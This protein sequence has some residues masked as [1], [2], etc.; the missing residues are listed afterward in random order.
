M[1]PAVGW[2]QRVLV[3]AG[4]VGVAVGIP[5]GLV[6]A[7]ASELGATA[8]VGRVVAVGAVVRG[9]AGVG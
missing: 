5:V 3:A 9:L 6:I 2:C 8:A 1:V 4:V 7:E